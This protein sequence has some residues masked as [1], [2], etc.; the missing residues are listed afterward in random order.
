MCHI[1]SAYVFDWLKVMFDY[2]EFFIEN[3]ISIDHS[4]QVRNSVEIHNN[5]ID[6]AAIVT[7]YKNTYA[8]DLKKKVTDIVK[9]HVL[10]L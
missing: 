9:K 5:E 2:N 6:E 8:I 1:S 10:M 7:L 3:G 4:E